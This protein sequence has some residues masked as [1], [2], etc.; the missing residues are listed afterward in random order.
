MPAGRA[1]GWLRYRTVVTMQ[2]TWSQ[3][4]AE[5]VVFSKDLASLRLLGQVAPLATGLR[6]VQRR[7]HHRAQVIAVLA[8]PL[9]GSIEHCFN[10]VHCSSVRVTWI[11]HAPHRDAQWRSG[12]RD[13]PSTSHRFGT[14]AF[15]PVN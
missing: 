15:A 3:P 6:D 8:A 2:A 10:S 4:V 7:L 1:P 9:A 11:H 13:T 12:N 14:T 5:A